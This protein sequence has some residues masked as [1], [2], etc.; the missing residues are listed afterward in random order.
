M[1]V[2]LYNGRKTVAVV[3]DVDGH[4]VMFVGRR[5]NRTVSTVRSSC[6]LQAHPLTHHWS[7]YL[8]YLQLS[9]LTAVC[10]HHIV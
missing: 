5:H 6:R 1:Y 7:V 4:I 10:S 2:D 8:F 9:V 3:V